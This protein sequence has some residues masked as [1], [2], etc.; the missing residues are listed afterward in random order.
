MAS[1]Q[2]MSAGPAAI[3]GALFFLLG[4]AACAEDAGNYPN[5]P[6]AMIVPFAPGGASISSPAS[7]SPV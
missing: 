4:A 5:K 7:S 6:V 1:L 2:R 3:G